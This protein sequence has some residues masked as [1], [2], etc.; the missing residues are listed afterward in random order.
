MIGVLQ[1]LLLASVILMVP[2]MII[3][4]RCEEERPYQRPRTKQDQSMRLSLF[5]YVYSVVDKY[6]YRD[7]HEEPMY[8][9]RLCLYLL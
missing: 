1:D 9:V 2:T 5:T 7:K 4:L 6:E 3:I 8:L